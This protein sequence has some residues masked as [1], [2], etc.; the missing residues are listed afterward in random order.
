MVVVYSGLPWHVAFGSVHELIDLGQ[1]GSIPPVGIK[2]WLAD[3]P[4]TG[5]VAVVYLK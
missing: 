4:T 3:T 2:S 5:S 1:A